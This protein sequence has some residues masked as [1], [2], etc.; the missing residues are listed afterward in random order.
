[1]KCVSINIRSD[2]G[3]SIPFIRELISFLEDKGI[4]ILLPGYDIFNDSNLLS[5]IASPED[6]INMP[7]IV[8]VVGGDGTLLRTARLFNGRDVPLFGINRGRLGFLT[9]FLPDE[10]FFYLEE[11]ISGE[12]LRTERAMLELLHKRKNTEVMKIAF[13]NDAVISRGSFLHPI[14]IHIGIDERSLYTFS[15]DGL[16]I[17]TA[18]GSTAYSL[19]AGGPIVTP[20]IKNICIVMPICPHTL[21]VRP[22]IVPTRTPIKVRVISE[23]EK[24]L[25][26][27]DGEETI[28]I[29]GD[30][31]FIFQ[32]TEKR[33]YLISHPK[34]NFY[35]KLRQKFG[36]ANMG[37]NR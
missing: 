20:S 15:G 16:I 7:D 35:E 33:V 17:S 24:I 30:D 32:E 6:F 36:L 19:S 28:P 27:I 37:G 23:S 9:E 5:Y 12:Y 18:T 13:L 21:A 26:R 29:E 25:L 3:E 8:A 1:M 14:K 11:V 22:M 31:E 34:R 4:R 2:D 10:S